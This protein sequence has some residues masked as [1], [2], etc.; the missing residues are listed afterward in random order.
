[1]PPVVTAARITVQQQQRLR[2]D[3]IIA[4]PAIEKQTV[5]YAVLHWRRRVNYSALRPS[6]GSTRIARNAG[7]TQA[8]NAA[9]SNNALAVINAVASLVVTPNTTRASALS[10]TRISTRPATK[11]I[12]T[13][14]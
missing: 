7:G 6:T 2:H 13:S 8:T 12:T 10:A 9:I 1:M 5:S 3:A 11:P 4:T 14:T